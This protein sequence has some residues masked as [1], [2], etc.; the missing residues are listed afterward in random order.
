MATTSKA[1]AKKSAARKASPANGPA[2]K[3][4]V[5]KSTAAK[6]AKKTAPAKA[7]L[8]PTAPKPAKRGQASAPARQRPAA[9]K[10]P[11]TQAKT[12]DSSTAPAHISPE[13]AV[14]HIQ[15]LLRAKQQRARRGPNWP[16]AQAGPTAADGN[17]PH[18]GATEGHGPQRHLAHA[19][20]DQGKGKA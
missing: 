13:E 2:G 16:G 9:V 5:R 20:G 17:A 4:S 12:T 3:P 10:A 14:A 8:K 19:R 6:P 1:A 7:G 11:A 15:A 18:G